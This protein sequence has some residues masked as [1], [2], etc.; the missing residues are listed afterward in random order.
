MKIKCSPGVII[1]PRQ[2]V[3]NDFGKRIS[4]IKKHI[5]VTELMALNLLLTH[6]ESHSKLSKYDLYGL[7]FGSPNGVMAL[8]RSHDIVIKTTYEAEWENPDQFSYSTY[9]ELVGV[10]K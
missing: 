10:F 9:F 6:Q 7:G 3:G 8:L 4:T 1:H 2:G 5:T